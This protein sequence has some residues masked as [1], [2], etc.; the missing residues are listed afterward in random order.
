[1]N[2]RLPTE[3][4]WEVAASWDPQADRARPYP[5]GDWEPSA[6]DNPPFANLLFA[7]YGEWD[8]A[9]TLHP[10]C[11]SAGLFERAIREHDIDPAQSFMVGDKVS[12]LIPARKLGIA[13]ALVLT[14][15]GEDHQEA[16][17]ADVVVTDV[18]AAADWIVG[19]QK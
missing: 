12:D 9:G 11:A 3:D 8:D 2:R 19:Q 5:W 4:E 17:S 6:Q 16:T 15:H 13:T 14:G 7:Q 10:I 1:Y 18:A